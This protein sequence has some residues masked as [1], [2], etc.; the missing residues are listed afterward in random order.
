MKL[1]AFYPD[2]YYPTSAAVAAHDRETAKRLIA[3]EI[4]REY[5]Y[6]A[7]DNMT[8][9]PLEVMLEKY[10]KEYPVNV[11]VTMPQS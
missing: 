7:E 2:S 4:V 3:A 10:T 1:Y 5:S 9:E 8:F 11:A 6:L